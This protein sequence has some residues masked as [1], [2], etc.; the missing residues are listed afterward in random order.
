MNSPVC[1]VCMYLCPNCIAQKPHIC[2]FLDGM[3]MMA[4]HFSK[5]TLL[6][7]CTWRIFRCYSVGY[8]STPPAGNWAWYTFLPWLYVWWMILIPQLSQICHNYGGTAAFKWDMKKFTI[9]CD[10]WVGSVRR[11]E[12]WCKAAV[13]GDQ[14][15]KGSNYSLTVGFI[16]SLQ[17]VKYRRIC[18]SHIQYTSLTVHTSV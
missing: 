12:W 9:L 2:S 7:T 6:P 18:S 10:S 15:L 1:T 8:C 16:V 5:A 17:G 13:T 14:S 11:E 4:Q 3:L